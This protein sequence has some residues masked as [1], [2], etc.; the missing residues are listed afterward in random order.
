MTMRFCKTIVAEWSESQNGWIVWPPENPDA[1]HFMTTVEMEDYS[2]DYGEDVDALVAAAK[3][4]AKSKITYVGSADVRI[5]ALLKA[6]RVVAG[7]ERK[8]TANEH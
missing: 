6:A 7:K 1:K 2:P 5:N 4:A 3:E 8:E